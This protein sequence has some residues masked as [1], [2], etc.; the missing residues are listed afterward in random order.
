MRKKIRKSQSWRKGGNRKCF[1]HGTKEFFLPSFFLP[2]SRERKR[3]GEKKKQEQ[4][5]SKKWS[6]VTN[7]EILEWNIPSS[8]SFGVEE[9]LLFLALFLQEKE[10][11]KREGN[12]FPPHWIT[13]H[14]MALQD[15]WF[16]GRDTR[17]SSLLLSSP[18]SLSLLAEEWRDGDEEEKFK[19]SKECTS[20]F[21]SITWKRW[22]RKKEGR[23][24]E[25]FF[26][27]K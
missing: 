17:H 5:R 16:N 12:V 3:N 25:A 9:S 22:R 7:R 13:S 8:C 2:F 18:S 27:T 14:F 21:L 1:L 6:H 26:V 24:R 10:R 11:K 20:P 23:K 4:E 15:S 19:E